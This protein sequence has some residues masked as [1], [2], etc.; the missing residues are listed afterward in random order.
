MTC[1][2]DNEQSVGERRAYKRVPVDV[3][4]VLRHR[5]RFFA[6]KSN[7]VSAGGVCVEYAGDAP[8]V[9]DEVEM[10]V[11]VPGRRGHAR[12][13]AEVRW[14]ARG[15]LGLMFRAGARAAVA[16]FVAAMLGSTAASAAASATV[17][18]FDPNA[19]VVIDM[20]GGGER[21]QDFQVMEAFEQQF[22]EFDQCIAR[23]KQGK[24][25]QLDGDVDVQVLLDPKG[26]RPLGIN[27][28]LPGKTGKDKGLREC[29]RSAVA[30][31]RFPS[32]N[33]P[34]I[35]V[36]FNFQLDP[37]YEEVQEQDW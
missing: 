27:A 9:G 18:E 22:G 17:P 6:A 35:V 2:P 21:P 25:T 15:R 16:A 13:H 36:E 24:E 19:D 26:D 1:I 4:V 7:D 28:A 10:E 37:G 23:A 34:P 12:V 33:G 31:A 5:D 30:A 32:Y 14:A 29:L 3:P 20:N 8:A 11:A